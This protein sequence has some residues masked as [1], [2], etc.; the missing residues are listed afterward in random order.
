MERRKE[1]DSTISGNNKGHCGILKTKDLSWYKL[2]QITSSIILN[3]SIHTNKKCAAGL[4]RRTHTG[5]PRK[6]IQNLPINYDY[7][8]NRK[9]KILKIMWS[10]HILMKLNA[11]INPVYIKLMLIFF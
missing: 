8:S 1:S 7:D 11:I 3:G 6:L 5:S 4:L 2:L 10:N 9:R